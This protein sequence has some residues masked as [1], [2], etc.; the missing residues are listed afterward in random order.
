MIAVDFQKAFDSVNRNVLYRALASFNFGPSFIQWVHTFYHNF[1]N[2]VLNNGF[3]TRPF[4]KQRGVRQGDPLSPYLFIVILSIRKNDNIQGIIVDGTEIKV[5]LFADDLI[6]LFRKEKSLRVFLE[7]VTKFGSVTGLIINFDKTE[8]LVLGNSI[9]APIED[10]CTG[11]IEIK[12]AV[13]ILGVYFTYNRPLRKK[14]NYDNHWKNS[15]YKKFC[16]SDV[17]VSSWFNLYQ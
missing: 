6:A 14:L 5:E 11:N 17:N 4:E 7:V 2:C 16:D 10:R 9:M 12:E 13:K 8:I 15:D 3:S 1:S